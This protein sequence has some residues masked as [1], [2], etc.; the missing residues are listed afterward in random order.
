MSDIAKALNFKEA[1]GVYMLYFMVAGAGAVSP[2]LASFSEAFPEASVT[3]VSLIQTLPSITIIIGTLLAGVVA[4]K[5]LPFKTCGVIALVIYLI[6]GVLPTFWNDSLE[7]ILVIRAICGFGMGFVSPLGAAAFLH[8]VKSEEERAKYL[9]RGGAMQQIGCVAM[10]LL[11][12]VLCAIDWRYTFLAYGLCLIVLIVFV[13]CFKEPPSLVSEASEDAS[14]AKVKPKEKVKV[15]GAAVAI[16]VIAV[17]AQLMMSPTMVEF[18]F[19]MTE[20]ITDLS[21]AVVT[22]ACGVLMSVFV[23]GGAI[24]SALMDKLMKLFGKF[25]GPVA[26]FVAVIGNVIIAMATSIPMFAVGIIVFGVGWCLAIPV[27]NLDASRGVN[28]ATLSLIPSLIWG[29]MNVGNF[30]ASYWLG[31]LGIIGGSATNILLIDSGI[32]AVLGVAWG[33]VNVVRKDKN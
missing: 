30:L 27:M 18:S 10:T 20:K 21:P 13:I 5:K 3:T 9:G 29:L 23:L 8:L 1:W 25:I 32:F 4:G 2:A 14:D 16:I 26:I 33:I 22:S 12:G 7:G 28:E 24:S 15:P 11:G 19:L 31:V 6:F 17:L